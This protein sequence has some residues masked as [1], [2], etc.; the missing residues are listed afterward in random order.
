MVSWFVR[1]GKAFAKGFFNIH[2]RAW[3]GGGQPKK[4]KGGFLIN[5]QTRQPV[6]QTLMPISQRKQP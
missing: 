1:H 2:I 6:M 4:S 3:K 5:Q